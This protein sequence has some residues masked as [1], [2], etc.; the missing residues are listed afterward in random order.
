MTP[1]SLFIEAGAD[2]DKLREKALIS[3]YWEREYIFILENWE[4]DLFRLT[5]PEAIRVEKVMQE[6]SEWE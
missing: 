6:V 3:R 5:E 1:R 4:K 2:I